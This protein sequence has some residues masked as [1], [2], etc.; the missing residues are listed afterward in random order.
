M[1][2]LIGSS[3]PKIA[4][5]GL[6]KDFSMLSCEHLKPTYNAFVTVSRIAL[7]SRVKSLQF[8]YIMS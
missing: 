2:D 5:Q 4:A 1:H 8:R 6:L 3:I 7:P